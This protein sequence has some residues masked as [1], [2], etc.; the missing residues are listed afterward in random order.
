MSLPASSS[1]ETMLPDHISQLILYRLDYKSLASLCL[2]SHSWRRLADEDSIWQFMIERL[3]MGAIQEL[4]K[5]RANPEQRAASSSSGVAGSSATEASTKAHQASKLLFR[6]LLHSK[7]SLLGPDCTIQAWGAPMSSLSK[8]EKEE[9]SSPFRCCAMLYDVFISR[10]ACS[11][12]NVLPGQYTVACRMKLE[13]VQL[14]SCT[15]V[16][17]EVRSTDSSQG[18][19]TSQLLSTSWGPSHWHALEQQH[20]SSWFE[21]QLGSLRLASASCSVHVVIR[22]LDIPWRSSVYLDYLALQPSCA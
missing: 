10:L 1:C 21:A 5:C 16:E 3:N 8:F 11:F 2:V 9:P 20:G 4:K 22:N 7:R 13:D 17:A 18:S 19:T 14:E 6:R 15:T 12:H